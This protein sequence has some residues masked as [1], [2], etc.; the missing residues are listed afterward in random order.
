[1]MRPTIRMA[2]D[3]QLSDAVTEAVAAATGTDPL[4]LPRFQ[5]VIDLDALDKLFPGGVDGR[6]SGA[7]VVFEVSG[8]EVHAAADGRVV[9]I[10]PESGTTT[11]ESATG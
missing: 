11:A 7:R 5:D 8:C 9:A 3:G 4:A 2:E 6:R 1:M 10:P